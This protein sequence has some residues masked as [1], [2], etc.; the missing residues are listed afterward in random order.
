MRVGLVVAAI[1]VALT[2][3]TGTAAAQTFGSNLQAGVSSLNYTCQDNGGFPPCTTVARS[4]DTGNPYPA[5]SPITGIL[6]R[7][8]FLTS[9]STKWTVRIARAVQG[10]VTGAGTGPTVTAGPGLVDVPVRMPI[11]QGDF[12]AVDGDFL[13]TVSSNGGG[14]CTDD[15]APVLRD[16]GTLG[17]LIATCNPQAMMQGEVEPDAD[18][19]GYGDQTQDNCPT[20]ANADQKDRN[21]DGTGDVCGDPDGDGI[22][23]AADNCPDTS[24]ADQADSDHDGQGDA[25]DPDDDNDGTPD[26]NDAFPLD[27]SRDGGPVHGATGARDVLSGTPFDDLICGLGGNDVLNGLSGNDTIFGDACNSASPSADD[28]DDQISGDEGNDSLFGQAGDDTLD[29]GLGD[30]KLDGGAGNDRLNGAPGNDVLVGGAGD[31]KVDGGDGNDLADGGDGNDSLSGGAGNDVLSGGRGNDT[32]T[33]GGGTNKYSGGAGNDTIRAKNGKRDA[34]DCG[35]GKK[36]KVVA[37]KKDRIKHCERRA[38][39]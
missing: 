18:G 36:D 9:H 1:A 17:N 6:V 29:G 28:G 23:D 21:G 19:D 10:G 15:Y 22:V 11:K 30:D 26:S 2:A 24:N 34:I 25:C 38:K 39:R 14:G 33:G 27:P 35:A 5:T 32:L 12:L 7:M 37:D 13:P 4:F 3:V 31:D 20:I 8:R 16:D